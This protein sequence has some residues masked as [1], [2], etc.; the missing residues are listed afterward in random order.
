VSEIC[1]KAKS[2]IYDDIRL[3]KSCKIR[4]NREYFLYAIIGYPNDARRT[5][6][7]RSPSLF[8]ARRG[9]ECRFMARGNVPRGEG[10]ACRAAR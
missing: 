9:G 7:A 10:G 8:A 3:S 2:E 1:H 6:K 5:A 4:I